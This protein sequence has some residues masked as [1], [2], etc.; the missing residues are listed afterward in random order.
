M[1]RVA[2]T[3]RCCEHVGR[4][5]A[6]RDQLDVPLVLKPFDLSQLLDVV[7]AAAAS[8]LQRQLDG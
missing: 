4:V 7:E 1:A 2:L 3:A 8:M 6:L 5:A